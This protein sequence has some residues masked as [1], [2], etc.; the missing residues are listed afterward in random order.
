MYV[1]YIIKYNNQIMQVTRRVL[2]WMRPCIPDLNQE[3]WNI[4]LLWLKLICVFWEQVQLG[5]KAI[6]EKKF[7]H[8]NL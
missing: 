3:S 6:G 4:K 1:D 2:L 8:P 7:W 5:R